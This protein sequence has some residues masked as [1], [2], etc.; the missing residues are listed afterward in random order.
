M[1]KVIKQFDG[2]KDGEVYPV[3]FN[4]GDE[5]TGDLAAVAIKEKWAEAEGEAVAKPE[6]KA[7]A[8]A[9]ETK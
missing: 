3:T 9:P 1:V 2:V 6:T 8:K 7:P 5:V 4:P